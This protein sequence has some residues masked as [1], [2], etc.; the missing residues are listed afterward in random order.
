MSQLWDANNPLLSLVKRKQV[1]RMQNDKSKPEIDDVAIRAIR[2]TVRFHIKRQTIHET[3]FD[4]LV[5]DVA[6]H[7]IEKIE[8]FD[9]ARASWSTYCSLIAKNYLSRELQRRKRR[10]SI[11]SL[12]EKQYDEHGRVFYEEERVE[13]RHS[14]S[15]IGRV[16]VNELAKFEMQEDLQQACQTLP[17]ELQDLCSTFLEVESLSEVAAQLGRSSK[18]IYRR[19]D[20][21]KAEFTDTCLGEYRYQRKDRHA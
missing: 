7:L 13:I 17:E 4:D 19:R 9:S 5:Q 1:R 16:P 14:Y 20:E 2:C 21:I 8:Y 11:G 18:T 12:S 10:P 6:L 3:D 15:S